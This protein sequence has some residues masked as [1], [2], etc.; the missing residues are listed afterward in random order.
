GGAGSPAAYGSL[1]ALR[2][3]LVPATVGRVPGADY[4]V[5]GQIAMQRDFNTE[6]QHSLLPVVGFVLALTF[7][8]MLLTFRSVGVALT[9][10]VLNLLSVGTAYGVLVLTFQRHWAEGLLGF[11]SN[12]GVLSWLPLVLFVILFGLSMDYHVF[13]V[14]RIREAALRGEPIRDAV[15]RRLAPP[16]RPV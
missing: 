13:V 9:A 3:G 4:A 6:M 5:G 1:D 12:G 16:G 7:L 11:R 15:A 10:I 14:S 2:G 8:V